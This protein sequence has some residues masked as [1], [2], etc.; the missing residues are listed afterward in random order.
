MHNEVGHTIMTTLK[1]KLPHPWSKVSESKDIVAKCDSTEVQ[2][3]ICDQCTTLLF[4]HM[5]INLETNRLIQS[6]INMAIIHFI[7]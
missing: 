6:M 2:N 5:C 4:P 1:M 3:L 7:L